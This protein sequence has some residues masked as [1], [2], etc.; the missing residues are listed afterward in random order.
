MDDVSAASAPSSQPVDIVRG[1]PPLPV[2]ALQ[3][4]LGGLVRERE[5]LRADPAAKTRLEQNRLAIAEAQRTLSRALIA[6]YAPSLGT[7]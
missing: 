4:L 5:L 2:E 6:R 7:I 3:D 1:Q